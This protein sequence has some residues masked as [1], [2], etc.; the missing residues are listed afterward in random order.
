MKTYR[1]T[2]IRDGKVFFCQ[3]VDHNELLERYDI[4]SEYFDIAEV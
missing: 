2:R 3:A 1:C 4:S